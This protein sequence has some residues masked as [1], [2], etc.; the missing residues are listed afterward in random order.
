MQTSFKMFTYFIY[1]CWRVNVILAITSPSFI[2]KN[3]KGVQ[4]KNLLFIIVD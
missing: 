2:G 4:S 3:P 1:W